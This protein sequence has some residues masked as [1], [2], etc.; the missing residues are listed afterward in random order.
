MNS[1]AFK[2]IVAVIAAISAV[3]GKVI[4]KA[5]STDPI[6]KALEEVVES[7]TGIDITEIIDDLEKKP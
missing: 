4:F 1:S 3:C 2:L 6:E 7:E 5:K